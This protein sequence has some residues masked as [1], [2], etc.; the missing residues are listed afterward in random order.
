MSTLSP[1]WWRKLSPYLD[2]ALGMND[3]ERAA[4]LA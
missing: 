4:W 1:D 3:E 2:A